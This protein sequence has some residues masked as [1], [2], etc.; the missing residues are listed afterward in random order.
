MAG[1]K[2]NIYSA[3]ETKG[4]YKSLSSDKKYAHVHTHTHTFCASPLTNMGRGQSVNLTHE[5]EV[6]TDHSN[7]RKRSFLL[8][9]TRACMSS[10]KNTSLHFEEEQDSHIYRV[11]MY[12][13]THDTVQTLRNWKYNDTPIPMSSSSCSCVSHIPLLPPR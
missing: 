11:A 3:A 7:S 10:M 12:V 9:D 2:T 13:P 8:R 6:I 5:S 1:K 4:G